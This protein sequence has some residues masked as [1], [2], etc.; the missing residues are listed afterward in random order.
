VREPS[1][2]VVGIFV[3]G[4]SSRYHGVPKGLLT[5]PGSTASIVA[6]LASIARGLD[7]EVVLVGQHPAYANVGIPMLE[8]APEARGPLAGLAALLHFAGERS[9][10]AVAC[11][12]PHVSRELF[13]RLLEAPRAAIV[14]ACRD[15]R[16][17]PLF[18]RYDPA[19]CR[20]AVRSAMDAGRYPLHAI[21]DGM[22]AQV[23]SLTAA[24]QR[25]LH[26]WDSPEDRAA[27]DPTAGS[28]SIAGPRPTHPKTRLEH[29]PL[30]I[31][32]VIDDVAHPSAG[33]ID[34]FVGLVRDHA[35]GRTVEALEYSAYEPMA[36]R[37]LAKIAG[38]IEARHDGVRIAARHRIGALRVGELAVVCAASAAHRDEAFVACRELIEELKQRVP[39]WK[40]E[41][42]PDGSA[43]VGWVDVRAA[44]NEEPA[45]RRPPE[46]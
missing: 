43:W 31:S 41:T 44:S 3:G 37:E 28:A 12:M 17:E 27:D 22:G 23:L 25:L 34:V 8:D 32:D 46:E 18:A 33:A 42:G 26:D 13:V 5:V 1:A 16:W 6:R 14:A 29:T 11:D 38:E 10:I 2:T 39:I 36:E 4:E 45:S 9:A 20:E 35:D 24:E 30:R 15:G 7:L 21:L 40:R 19:L